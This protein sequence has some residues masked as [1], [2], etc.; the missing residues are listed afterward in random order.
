MVKN[1]YG[2]ELTGLERRRREKLKKDIWA[3]RI[4]IVG[5]G[6]IYMLYLYFI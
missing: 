3:D 2:V 1:I 6:L 4:V 5:C